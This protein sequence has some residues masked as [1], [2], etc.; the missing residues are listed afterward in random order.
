MVKHI[1]SGYLN[2]INLKWYAFDERI[3]FDVFMLT[4]DHSNYRDQFLS[5][6][7]IK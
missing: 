6:V 7:L 5:Y 4:A 2:N 1:N 3:G